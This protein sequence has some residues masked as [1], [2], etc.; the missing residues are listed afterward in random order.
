M[1]LTNKQKNYIKKQYKKTSPEQLA[2]DLKLPK[3]TIENYINTIKTRQPRKSFYI[4]LVLIPILFFI[5]LEGSLRIFNYG[6]DYTTFIKISDDF[7][8]LLFLNPDI[9]YKYFSNISKAP[10]VFPDGFEKVKSDSTF[11]VF[12]MGGSSAAGWPFAHS[13]AFSRYIKRRLELLYPHNKIEVIN[14][15]IAAVNSFTL[16]DF[17]P[18]VL[19]QKPDLILFY[20]GHNEYYGALGVA[21]SESFG[22]S[23]YLTNLFLSLEN[24][25]TTQLIKSVIKSIY[26]FIGSKTNH[27]K[28]NETLM[29]K[30]IGESAI[31]LN[32]ELYRDGIDQFKE[33]FTNMLNMLRKAKVNVVIS[34]LESNLL[35]KPFISIP[36]DSL[37]T[38]ATVFREAKQKLR[39]NKLTQA[40]GLFYKA[41]DL[42]G[43]RFRA[44]SEIN[45]V[46]K[47]LAKQFNYPLI[48][49]DSVFNAN[50]P[51]KITGYNLTVDHLHPNV[52]G[53]QLIGKT[54]FEEMNKQNYLPKHQPL[55]IP[56]DTQE[57]IL[58]SNFPFTK[59]DSTVADFRLKKLL[60]AYPFVPKNTP[61]YLLKAIK[62]KTTVDST[63]AHLIDHDISWTNAHYKI[64]KMYLRKGNIRL[65]K[66]EIDAM[67]DEF[68]FDE[69]FYVTAITPLIQLKKY[70]DA[71]PYII[72]L[73]K[74]HSS[75]Y[76]N[77]WRGAIE[78]ELKHYKRAITYLNK[79]ISLNPT[80]AQVFYNLA[81]AYYFN[82]QTDKAL[83]AIRK[84]ISLNPKYKQAINFYNSLKHLKQNIYK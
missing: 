1:A 67:I 56:N 7:P 26:K 72:K 8:N 78:L 27:G 15:G 47:K 61:N 50:S 39:K 23:G 43:L 65:F 49:I 82:R 62:L 46:I 57:K 63:A 76:T 55:N 13:A 41:K 40:R 69:N 83:S 84:S 17:L 45:S 11:R 9:P 66:K 35:Q 19:K 58:K 53:Y 74:M 64:A 37:P 68:P 2:K 4:I 79:S 34:T 31:P 71:L 60:G 48:N 3:E 6:K 42:D 33:N 22:N 18:D 75:A 36:S 32:S 38:A 52:K 10:S 12:V 30:M 70:S 16:R 29:E 81:G 28:P 14:L 77:K 24:F 44:P 5:L 54:F 21:S 59:L 51:D 80:D 25:K 73:D 20:F